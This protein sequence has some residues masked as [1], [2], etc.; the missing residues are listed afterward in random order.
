ME[1]GGLRMLASGMYQD[2]RASSRTS[3]E[4]SSNAARARSYL[5]FSKLSGSRPR[6]ASS[7]RTVASAGSILGPLRSRSRKSHLHG[8]N[9]LG[10]TRIDVRH[11]RVR[12]GVCTD[13]GVD[14]GA[15]L[16]VAE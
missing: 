6:R 1:S 16:D 10:V 8:A 14:Q 9:E 13:V 7:W 3:A 5:P 2:R 15:V 12:N 11:H 4:A